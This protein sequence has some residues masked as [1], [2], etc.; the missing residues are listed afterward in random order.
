MCL[1][2]GSRRARGSILSEWRVNNWV[3]VCVG[4]VG[5]SCQVWY[6]FLL[7]LVVG[8]RKGL[9]H[10]EVEQTGVMRKGNKEGFL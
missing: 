1:K 3:N 7:C 6:S 8:C 9:R 4:G 10:Y 5:G 2:L